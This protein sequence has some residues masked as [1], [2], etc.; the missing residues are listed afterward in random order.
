MVYLR[1][2]VTWQ[3]DGLRLLTSSMRIE[4]TDLAE[5]PLEDFEEVYNSIRNGRTRS[6]LQ[7]LKEGI[8]R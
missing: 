4:E 6:Y 8:H 5:M 7:G 3:K 1:R 2:E